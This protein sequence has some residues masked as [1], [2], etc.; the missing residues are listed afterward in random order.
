MVRFTVV[1]LSRA[2]ARRDEIGILAKSAACVASLR[3]IATHYQCL[4][5]DI[6]EGSYVPVCYMEIDLP[7][8][9]WFSLQQARRF[10]G[11]P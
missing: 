7:A 1:P 5:T 11:T 10:P 9:K 6:L 3:A 2:L 8:Q 4:H